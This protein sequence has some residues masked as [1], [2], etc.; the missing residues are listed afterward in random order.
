MSSGSWSDAFYK[1]TPSVD[2]FRHSCVPSAHLPLSHECRLFH[3]ACPA[4]ADEDLGDLEADEDEG[5]G[6]DK[7]LTEKEIAAFRKKTTGRGSAAGKA[8][9]AGAGSGAKAKPKAAAA[10]GKGAGASKAKPK[11]KKKAAV[12][13][14]D[15][16]EEVEFVDD[17]DDDE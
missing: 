10:A 2:L 1:L 13:D 5:N 14:D 7:P 12:D 3:F 9:G 4:V 6:E 16:E 15:D 11:A 8:K 17:E